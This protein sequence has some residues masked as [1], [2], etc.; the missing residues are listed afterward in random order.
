[1]TN[2]TVQIYGYGFGTTPATIEVTLDG[3]V[4][5]NGAI[6][7]TTD[8][9]PTLPDMQLTSDTVAICSF[10]LP[11]N[12]SGTI[13]MACEVTN[14]TVIFAQVLANYFPIDNPVYTAEELE[15]IRNPATTNAEKIAIISS[16]ATP[17]F[18][19]ED[20]TFIETHT[21]LESRP[22]LVEHNVALRI[23]STTEYLNI[24]KANDPR[25]NIQIDGS[26]KTTDHA[27]YPGAWWWRIGS[28][29]TLTYDL[30]VVAGL[31]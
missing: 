24:N 16:H 1:M 21:W 18:S 31:D 28:G 19:S 9:I 17:P 25:S 22:L 13:P 6:T 30:N 20:I 10:E 26:P 8:P 15:I 4:V 7:T 23:G 14:G 2:R 12:F 27:T 11:V 29:S 5:Y 3:N